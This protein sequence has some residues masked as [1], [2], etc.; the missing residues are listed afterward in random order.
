ML[1]YII[2]SA[3]YMLNPYVALVGRITAGHNLSNCREPGRIQASA[4][5]PNYDNSYL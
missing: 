1:I 3:L 4:S 2:P 5:K